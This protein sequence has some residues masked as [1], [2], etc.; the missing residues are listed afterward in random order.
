MCEGAPPRPRLAL[1]LFLGPSPEFTRPS[2]SSWRCFCLRSDDY[3]HLSKCLLWLWSQLGGMSPAS[4]CPVIDFIPCV[5]KNTLLRGTNAPPLSGS[6]GLWDRWLM[7]LMY[8][9]QQF[10]DNSA[11][12]DSGIRFNLVKTEKHSHSFNNKPHPPW[13]LR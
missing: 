7:H 4:L 11:L 2:S 5:T 10:S 9:S 12:V 6:P 1:R 8:S 3:R 13:H